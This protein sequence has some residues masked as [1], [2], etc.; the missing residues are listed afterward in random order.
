MLQDRCQTSA[1]DCPLRYASHIIPIQCGLDTLVSLY[2]SGPVGSGVA[3]SLH[4]IREK[5]QTTL[6]P[7]FR[8]APPKPV[9]PHLHHITSAEKTVISPFKAS[10]FF[11]NQPLPALPQPHNPR[12][13][14][15]SVGY[16]HH[17]KQECSSRP[18]QSL[19]RIMVIPPHVPQAQP[20]L[21]APRKSPASHPMPCSA[22]PPSTTQTKVLAAPCGKPTAPALPANTVLWRLPPEKTHPA[23]SPHPTAFGTVAPWTST[24]SAQG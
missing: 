16:I 4:L 5:N 14:V 10:S 8:S 17:P 23:G 2:A 7:Y 9:Q 3:Q 24:K 21:P 11:S 13:N 6:S 18:T 1:K 22:P 19:R 15:T 20:P 12:P